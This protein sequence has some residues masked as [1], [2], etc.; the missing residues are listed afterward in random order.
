MSDGPTFISRN[1]FELMRKIYFTAEETTKQGISAATIDYYRQYQNHIVVRR[2]HVNGLGIRRLYKKEDVL[3]VVRNTS[4]HDTI[5][6]EIID[7]K[8]YGS[9]EKAAAARRQKQTIAAQPEVTSRGPVL[10]FT[11]KA[12]DAAKQ[13]RLFPTSKRKP[14]RNFYKPENML[15]TK[16]YN[17]LMA[18]L[19]EVR[20]IAS[21]IPEMKSKIDFLESEWRGNAKPEGQEGK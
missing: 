11:K 6:A 3:R 5:K 21:V 8:R 18:V 12:I 9:V 16:G 4:L 7:V 2:V 15:S 19:K 13:K 14:K 17:R 1:D 10:T 20:E